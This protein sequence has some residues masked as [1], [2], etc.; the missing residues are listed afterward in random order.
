MALEEA[1]NTEIPDEESEK[2]ATVQQ[3]VDYIS[4]KKVLV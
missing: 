2:L 1:F 4:Q 3:A